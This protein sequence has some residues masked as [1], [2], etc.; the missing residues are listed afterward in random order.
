MT[1][2]IPLIA[3]KERAKD[4]IYMESMKTT[5]SPPRWI[6]ESG[7]KRSNTIRDK[8]GIVVDGE[9][10]PPPLTRFIDFKFPSPILEW[11]D[12]RNIKKPTAIQV[13]G[14]PVLYDVHP[15]LARMDTDLLATF[16]DYL[17][18]I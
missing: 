3:V 5:W 7:E 17:A 2:D 9:D 15:I 13:Q 4:I 1:Q 10:V 16:L 6:L 8:W 14:M 12:G 11:L 18:V